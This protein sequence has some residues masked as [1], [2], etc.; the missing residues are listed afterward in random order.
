[1]QVE[2]PYYSSFEYPCMGCDVNARVHNAH[3]HKCK[4]VIGIMQVV[5]SKLH[6]REYC[7][8]LAD[9][10]CVS[11]QHCIVSLLSQALFYK[12]SESMIHS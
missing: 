10:L 7:L 4:C 9:H 11:E 6:F 5:L 12:S 2:Q 1:M 8:F 3:E